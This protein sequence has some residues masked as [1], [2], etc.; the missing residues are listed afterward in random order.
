MWPCHVFLT[1]DHPQALPIVEEIELERRLGTVDIMKEA[2]Q[3]VLVAQHSRMWAWC[4]D[5][6]NCLCVCYSNAEQNG[7][8]FIDEIDKIA[9]CVAEV[10]AV[11]VW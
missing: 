8:V 6:L 7:I 11:V 9:A 10:L 3:Y 4:A 1:V 2:I 5:V